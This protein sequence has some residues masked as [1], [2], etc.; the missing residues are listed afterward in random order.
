MNKFAYL[1]ESEY[2]WN[3]NLKPKF[4]RIL[5]M[6]LPRP[7]ISAGYGVGVVEAGTDQKLDNNHT[8]WNRPT[9]SVHW[10]VKKKI[11]HILALNVPLLINYVGCLCCLFP[12][13]AYCP[14]ALT[15]CMPIVIAV[16]STICLL[17]ICSYPHTPVAV[18][19]VLHIVCML[20]SS[21]VLS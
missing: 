16:L 7:G 2:F 10:K 17:S 12:L 4:L 1:S 9:K 5:R 20:L 18:N 19:I 8:R 11:Y 3:L 14:Y 21:W 6:D 15:H 13:Y